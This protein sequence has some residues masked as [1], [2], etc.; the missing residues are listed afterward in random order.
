MEKSRI[1]GSI[2]KG[3]IN[4]VLANTNFTD[5]TGSTENSTVIINQK[6]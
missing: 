4:Q 2:T 6:K 3:M 5:N 1:W